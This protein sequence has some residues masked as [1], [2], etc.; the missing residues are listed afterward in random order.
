MDAIT[1][2]HWTH[3]ISWELWEKGMRNPKGDAQGL[4]ARKMPVLMRKMRGL[5]GDGG[6]GRPGDMEGGSRV[7]S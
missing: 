4:P 5:E 3:H 7:S 1:C 6:V 2:R